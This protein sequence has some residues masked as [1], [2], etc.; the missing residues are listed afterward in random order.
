LTLIQ[1]GSSP[2]SSANQQPDIWSV[3]SVPR[4]WVERARLETEVGTLTV[5]RLAE[6]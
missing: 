6:V 5:L 2:K 4:N 1:A 3:P